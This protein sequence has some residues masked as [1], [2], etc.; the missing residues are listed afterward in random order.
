[1][2]LAWA[3]ALPTAALLNEPLRSGLTQPIG[4]PQRVQAGV[5][6]KNRIL[7]GQ[8]ADRPRH[9]LWMSAILAPVRVG[10][11]VEHRVPFAALGVHL[12]PKS[13]V[14]FGR[15]VVEQQL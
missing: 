14:A 7:L 3:S 1:M 12:I 4:R 2:P 5:K 11:L 6:D 9:R 10:L 13:R 15:D 8:V